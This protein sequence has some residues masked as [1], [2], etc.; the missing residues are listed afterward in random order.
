[1]RWT[2]VFLSVNHV[3]NKQFSCATA[4]SLHDLVARRSC[5]QSL[6]CLILCAHLELSLWCMIWHQTMLVIGANPLIKM[7][8]LKI[9][10]NF[11]PNGM[12]WLIEMSKK[13]L[14]SQLQGWGNCHRSFVSQTMFFMNGLPRTLRLD[15]HAF[16]QFSD[17]DYAPD[18]TRI[19]IELLVQLA[20][21]WSYLLRTIRC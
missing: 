15:V 9:L 6:P 5:C 11:I 3:V 10:Q 8:E 1:M 13:G 4:C 7:K 19:I 12:T 2:M 20:R 17:F 14:K 18:V 16:A 21:M